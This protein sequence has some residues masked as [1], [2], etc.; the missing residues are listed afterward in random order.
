MSSDTAFDVVIVTF[1]D[2]ETLP[3][4]LDAVG[5]LDPGPRRVLVVDNASSD[6]SARIARTNG[7]EV[8][9]LE[10]N[11]GFTGGM[12]L[13]IATTDAPWVLALNPDCAPRRDFCGRLF[14]AVDSRPERDEIGS[15]TG[16]LMRSRS[17]ELTETETVDAAGMVVT[18]SGRHFDRG[19]GEPADDRV[20]RDAWV[21]GGTGAATMYRRSALKDVAYPDGQVFPESFFCYRED[22]E[23]AWRLQ[24]RGWRCLYVAGAVA[25]HRRGFR[26]EEGRRD[27][28]WINRQ[29]VRNRFLLR[30]HCAD[31]GW[32]LRCF[33]DWFVRDALV[34]G[35]CLTIERKSLHG[36]LEAWRLRRQ[37]LKRRK[38]VM[39]R[40]TV[41]SQRVSRW[42]RRPRGKV[43]LLQR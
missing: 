34:L 3:A 21:F 18:P 16:L 29:S 14:E 25:A 13:G 19:A 2:R 28:T 42:F 27:A 1:D 26:P 12:N 41:P 20:L 4:C 31:A 22:A 15:V 9:A 8:L 40:T 33:P 10:R 30:L 5:T 43:E 39:S 23:L 7:A 6:D 32:H 36:I 11:T 38:W 35:A 37:A 24:F 17:P